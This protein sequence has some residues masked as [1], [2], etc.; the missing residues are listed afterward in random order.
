MNKAY[1]LPAILLRPRSFPRVF[2]ARRSSSTTPIDFSTWEAK[3]SAKEA[4]EFFEKF[5]RAGG[6]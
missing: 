6:S 4:R 5:D 3:Y 1:L 2:Y